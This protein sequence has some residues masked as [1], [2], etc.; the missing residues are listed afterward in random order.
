M[1]GGPPQLTPEQFAAAAAAYQQDKLDPDVYKRIDDERAERGERPVDLVRR[2]ANE[3]LS[4]KGAFS[5][6]QIKEMFPQFVARYGRLFSMLMDPR[7]ERRDLDLLLTQWESNMGG[8]VVE[9]STADKNTE[10]HNKSAPWG[11]AM[12]EKYIK[13]IIGDRK[14]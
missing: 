9:K 10:Y 4:R 6:S 11:A 13:P 8:I 7:F 3:I 2:Y 1:S 5:S 12:G 14:P